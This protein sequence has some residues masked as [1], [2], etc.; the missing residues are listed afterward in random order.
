MSTVAL[1]IE[2]QS[3]RLPFKKLL[4]V[5]S[6][7]CLCIFV[8]YLDQT[9]VSTVLPAIAHDLGAADRINWVGISFLVATTSSQIIIARLSD[10]FGRKA[11]LISATILFTFGNLLSGFA[12][13]AIWLFIARAIAGIGG[14]GINS[15]VNIIMSDVVS[16]K[17]R[18]KYQ[19][20][21]AAACAV[22]SGIGPLIGGALSTAGWRWV[23]WFTVP[24]TMAC[25]IQLWWML[26]QNKMNGGF[27]E[28][29]RKVDFTGSI[30]SLGAVVLVL[31]PL[32]GGGVYYS[33]NSAL[34]ITMLTIVSALTVVF[35]LVEWRIAE[36]PILPLYLFRLKN[37]LIVSATTFL[38][39][40]VFFC[41]LYFLP[42]YYTDARGFTPTQAGIYLLPLVFIQIVSTI[43][44]GQ[45]L[46]KTQYPRP[47][48]IVGFALWTI[49]AG[50][51]SMFDLDTGKGELVGYLLLEG[52]GIGLTFQTT[53][54]AAQASA[55][56]QERAV[57]TGARNFFRSLGG[58]I[59][60]VVC[61]ATK[62]AVL[63]KELAKIPNLSSK[64]V[65]AII[66]LGPQALED[67]AFDGAVR[68]AYMTSLHAI[69]ILF[70][71]IAGLSTIMSLFMKDVYLEG[72]K[73]VLPVVKTPTPPNSRENLELDNIQESQTVGGSTLDPSMS[74][75]KS[76]R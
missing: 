30:L 61:T 58:A 19:G 32:S 4:L 8:S 72:D 10:I 54:V 36:L 27:V 53:L 74:A 76:T 21:L 50:L 42:S 9:S 16:L 17:D 69:F 1:A 75:E 51:Q 52:I 29:L 64:A 5:I 31:V 35:I 22:G 55:P 62:N 15:L 28:K 37:I 7:L 60:L 73:N 57:I 38:T 70:V 43:I 48:V 47:Y 67:T 68:A 18:G 13:T 33:W 66:K 34:V 45:L 56:P 23:F 3:H 41:N 44:S 12:K 65:A 71:P 39:G 49:G 6:S 25:V 40:I 63:K 2:D 59:G 24:I 26:P 14:G 46:S 11:L 20:I